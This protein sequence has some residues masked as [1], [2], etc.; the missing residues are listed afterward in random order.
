[1]RLINILAPL[2]AIAALSSPIPSF[3]GDLHQFDDQANFKSSGDYIR[4]CAGP[5]VSVNC[6][7]DFVMTDIADEKS[8]KYCLPDTSAASLAQGNAKRTAI[9]IGLVAW[10]KTHP[11][12]AGKPVSEGLFAAMHASYPCH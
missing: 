5:K 12:Y 1:M 11:E 8:G 3:G 10:L 6:M 2:C 9:V 7:T 4:G